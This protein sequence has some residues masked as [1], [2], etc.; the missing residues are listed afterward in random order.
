MA[1]FAAAQSAMVQPFLLA[2]NRSSLV[3]LVL[4]NLFGQ[5]AP[6]IAAVEA[7]YE[8]MWA[9]DVSTM[10]T[11]HAGA[12]AAAASLTP[13]AQPLQNLSDLP[14]RVIAA[15]GNGAPGNHGHRCGHG[16]AATGRR[17]HCQLRARQYR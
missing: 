17:Q 10:A 12:S 16:A 8:Q 6:A 4:S 7:E 15:F 1:E 14:G 9:L 3:S 2:A 5:N 11:Y 13:L